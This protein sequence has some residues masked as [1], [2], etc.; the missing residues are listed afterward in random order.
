MME[1][2]INEYC[3][4]LLIPESDFS[5]SSDSERPKSL[6]IAVIS[7]VSNEATRETPPSY[8]LPLPTFTV[9]IGLNT[10]V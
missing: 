5:Q 3:E 7:Y 2:Q 1:V 4:D 6:K 9:N 10:D 8:F